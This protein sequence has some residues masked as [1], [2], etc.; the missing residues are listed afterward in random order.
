MRMTVDN[1]II[2]G[3]EDEEF[4]D[5]QKRDAMLLDKTLI[6]KRK[7]LQLW[8]KANATIAHAWCGAF[9]QTSDGLPLIGQVPGTPNIYAAYGYGGN[10]ITFSY[11]ASRMIAA[12]ISGDGQAWFENFALDRDP[13]QPG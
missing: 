10:G 12:M 13:K 11:L 5:P 3:G 7:L 8:P 2:I 6:L 4:S 1:R 9:G